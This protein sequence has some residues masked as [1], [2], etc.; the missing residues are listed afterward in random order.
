MK[1][2]SAFPSK[3]IKAADIPSG[4]FVKLRIDRA[5]SEN[6]GGDQNPEDKPV[7][8]FIG[9]DKGMV[10]NRTNANTIIDVYGDDTDTWHGRYVEVYQTQVA[11]QGKMVDSLR[12]RVDKAWGREM[13]VPAPAPKARP[14]GRSATTAASPKTTSPSKALSAPPG[15]VALRR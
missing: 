2:S 9:K 15:V 12:I 11:F 8:Y 7:L 3:Y 6:V 4:K 14:S 13:P 1:M 10:L 5:E